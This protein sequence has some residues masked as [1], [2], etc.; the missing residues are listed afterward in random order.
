MPTKVEENCKRDEIRMWRDSGRKEV[1]K[2]ELRCMV[3][4]RLI[5]YGRRTA[6]LKIPGKK[7]KREAFKICSL[8]PEKGQQ[9]KK[10]L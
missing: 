7:E 9:S 3:Y 8:H 4:F 10:P 6:G 5:F 2:D 1:Y